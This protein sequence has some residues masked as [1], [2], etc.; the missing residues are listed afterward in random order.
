MSSKTSINYFS[1]FFLF[2]YIIDDFRDVKRE[3]VIIECAKVVMKI[4][5]KNK[6]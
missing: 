6:K 1:S 2:F 3:I 5:K 4:D